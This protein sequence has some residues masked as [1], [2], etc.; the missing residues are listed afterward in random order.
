MWSVAVYRKRKGDDKLPVQTRVNV[1]LELMYTI[2]PL[3]MLAVL[4]RWTATDV[5]IVKDVS[6]P[7][8]VHIQAI[9]KQWAW[10]FNYLDDNVYSAGVQAKLTGKPGVEDTLPTLYLPVGEKVDIQLNSRD[11]I[12]SFWVPAFLFKQDMIPGR[13]SHV[14]LIPETV[15]TTTASA[16]SCAVS[17]TPRC[18]ST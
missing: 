13:T 1:P 5:A 2:V 14:Q 7:A 16:P 6:G 9:G 15:G 11:V 10:D 8:D 17:I 4:F 3:I 12:H 18:S